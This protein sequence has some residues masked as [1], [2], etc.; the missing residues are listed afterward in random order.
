VQDDDSVLGPIDFLAVEFPNGRVTNR[1]FT[2]LLDL[3]AR[4]IVRVLDLEFVARSAEGAVRTVELD[5]IEHDADMDVAA[6]QAAESRLLDQADV[7]AIGADLA[8][9][10]VAGVVVYEN[11]WA[12]PLLTA[13]D[14]DGARVIAHGRVAVEDVMSALETDAEATTPARTPA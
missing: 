11:V 14:G 12:T 2:C 8:P 1:G 7:Q 13:I 6:W 10:S 9:G 3:V 5:A 4:D